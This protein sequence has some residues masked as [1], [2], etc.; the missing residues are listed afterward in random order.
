[1]KSLLFSC[2]LLFWANGHTQN[3]LDLLTVGYST[4]P[5][6]GYDSA[7]S[8]TQ[9]RI[10]NMDLNLLLPIPLSKKT[11]ILTGFNGY[12]N[13]L[14]L[15]PDGPKTE[16]Y[17]AA[18][19]LGLNKTYTNGW[20][21]THLLFPRKTGAYNQK[22]FSYQIGMANL[23]QKKLSNGNGWGF[24]F[25]MNTEEQGLLF[26]PLFSYFLRAESGLWEFNA[27]LPSRADFTFLLDHKIR[28]GIGFEGLGNSYATT[29]E[30]YGDSY[31]QRSSAE[32]S[33]YLQFPITKNLLLNVRG[34][35]AFFRGYRVYDTSD[36]VKFSF[37]N[38][39][40]NS[41]RTPLNASVDDGFFF[42]LKLFYRYYLTPPTKIHRAD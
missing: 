2:F 14:N 9:T 6:T 18:V 20:S 31:V 26:V 32:V 38:L 4:T 40:I 16:L 10:T 22:R 17:T 7:L 3:Y 27:L 34:G 39:F 21:S 11:A 35:Y 30:P 37:L 8:N 19:Q 12:M 23:L 33:P 25:Y 41:S 29:L 5:N 42:G 36:T 15:S 1:M 28:A 24:G 13:S